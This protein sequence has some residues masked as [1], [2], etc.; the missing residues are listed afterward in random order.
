MKLDLSPEAVG[1]RLRQVEQLR[2]LCLSLAAAG[3]SRELA[4]KYPENQVLQ[5]TARALGNYVAPKTST[6]QDGEWQDESENWH[7]QRPTIV[8]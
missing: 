3:V 5:R 8:E 2:R 6:R 7:E 4:Q 1:Q